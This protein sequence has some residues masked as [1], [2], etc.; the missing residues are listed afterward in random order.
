M[1]GG[2]ALIAVLDV[3]RA[4]EL[5]SGWLIAVKAAEA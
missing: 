1:Q 3:A 2:A 4:Y 5:Q